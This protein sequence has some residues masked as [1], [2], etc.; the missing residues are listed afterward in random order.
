[1]AGASSKRDYYEVLGVSRSASADDIKKAYRR[2]ARQYHPDYNK[3]P[4]AADKFKELNEA[5]EVLSDPD[6]RSM[7][8]RFGHQAVGGAAGGG[9]DPFGGMGG[10]GAGDIFSSIFEQ[11]MNQSARSGGASAAQRGADLRYRLDIDFTEAIFGTEKEVSFQRLDTCTTCGGSGAEPG[12][13][14]VTCPKCNGQGELRTRAPIFNMLTVVTCDQC[15]GTGQVVETPC[16]TCHGDGRTRVTRR[17][18]VT[19]PQGVDDGMQI[20]LRGEGEGGLR[21]GPPGDLMIVL[22]VRPHPLFQ[23]NNDDVVL[24]LPLNVAQAAL[25]AYLTV[26]TVD[27]DEPLTVPPG[28]QHEQVFRLRG[29]G[30]PRLRGSGRGDQ[31]VVAQII[32][33]TNL[34]DRQRDLLEELA[35]EWG[36]EPLE[37]RDEG[38]FGKIKDAL[39]F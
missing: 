31:L 18:T 27:G 17:V 10:M 11:F 32:V 21:G 13:K 20:R 6:K 5:N 26:P 24:V 4:D 9:Y 35:A 7:Y 28:T 16:H 15:N 12:T 34:T 2:L 8:D 36:T 30:S 22:Q 38:F 14:K 33:P 19:I 37:K 23:R 25:G 1:M 3:E 29:K 39:G